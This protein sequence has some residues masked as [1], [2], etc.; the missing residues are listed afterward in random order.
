M[1]PPQCGA[2]LGFTY[3]FFERFL[4][5]QGSG[6]EVFFRAS[7]THRLK[8]SSATSEVVARCIGRRQLSTCLRAIVEVAYLSRWDTAIARL[9]CQKLRKCECNESPRLGRKQPRSCSDEEDAARHP[10]VGAEGLTVDKNSFPGRQ[11]PVRA[12]PLHSLGSVALLNKKSTAAAASRASKAL[13]RPSPGKQKHAGA[14]S[15]QIALPKVS[16]SGVHG[17]SNLATCFHRALE[18]L[19]G[20]VA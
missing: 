14:P 9:H 13:R 20:G 6:C 15:A 8:V 5:V 1:L 18:S 4:S 19:V 17:H 16:F 12:T 10:A 2:H 3:L 7:K 11:T